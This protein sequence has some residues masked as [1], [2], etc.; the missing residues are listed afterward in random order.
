MKSE[1][2]SIGTEI[3]LG[4]IT[5]TNASYVSGELPTLGID[6][7]WISQVGDNRGRL[8]E[9]LE[10]AWKR[11]DLVITTGGLGP[12]E[13]DITRQCIAEMLGEK[14]KIDPIQAQKIEERF[15]RSGR[16]MP[17]SNI[18]QAAVIPS[19]SILPNGRGTAPGWWIEK[20]NHILIAMPGPPAEM[21]LMWQKEVVPRLQQQITHDVIFSRTI[22][23]WGIS[24]SAINEMF[25]PLFSQANP[26][27][28]I[29][30]KADGIH[31]R[32]TAK[33]PDQ[34]Q[35]E[36]LI[37]PVE[38]NVRLALKEN[39]WGTDQDTLEDTVGKLLTEKKLSLAVM[40]GFT[41]GL[42]AHTIS[43]SASTKL[44]FKGGIVTSSDD[45]LKGFGVN[46]DIDSAGTAEATANVVRQHFHADIGVSISD[47]AYPVTPQ[48][49][50]SGNIYIGIAHGG[51]KKIVTV[52]NPGDRAEAR[53]WVVSSALFEIISM[54]NSST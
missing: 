25:I 23:T 26:T 5:D 24:E 54:L 46:G 30:V 53:R 20:G 18:K 22:K 52:R 8:L 6:L 1:I 50:P 35:A 32:L 33:A 16:T 13:G 43:S 15:Q 14:I 27:V 2:I 28:A 7:Y 36:E 21:H 10:R 51:S 31:M 3:L 44:S 42:L 49:K 12:S 45:V 19:A 4:E 37:A 41:G 39:I 29:Y 40:E 47:T 17:D 9:V 48:K 11:S 38:K 34:N